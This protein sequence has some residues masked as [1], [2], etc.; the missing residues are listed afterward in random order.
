[1]PAAG[2]LHS[3]AE[4]G[5]GCGVGLAWLAS[6]AAPGTRLTS[7]ERDPDRARIAAEFFRG[8]P[9]VVIFHGDWQRVEEHGPHDVLVLDGGGQAKGDGAA[10]PARLLAAGGT[11]VIDGFTPAT[12]WP[13]RLNGSPTSLDRTGSKTPN[14][15]P[16]S[17]A[18]QQTSA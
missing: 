13:P 7:V 11:V 6:G 15:E 10:D 4:T 14:F 8:C 17:Y 12:T 9:N 3:S 2:A 18:S 1:M 5:T 16:Q